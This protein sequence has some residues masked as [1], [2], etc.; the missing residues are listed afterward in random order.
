MPR[1]VDAAAS[2][3]RLQAG[4]SVLALPAAETV[5]L[6]AARFWVGALRAR[7]AP[8]RNWPSVLV[9]AGVDGE[10]IGAFHAFMLRLAAD[11]TRSVDVRCAN[12]PSL[13]PDEAM[14]IDVVGALQDG[15]RWY[16]TLRCADI[17]PAAALV[18]AVAALGRLGR[19]LD[20][21]G[22][23]VGHEKL[24]PVETAAAPV[25]RCVD[26]D[27]PQPTIH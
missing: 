25:H 26:A 11:A 2:S 10:A 1:E 8:A 18:P 23:R 13:S 15:R 9:A 14:L 16:A 17:L 4:M 20:A 24:T 3:L 7:A 21:A 22:L 27:A 6:A 5:V 19:S 12:C